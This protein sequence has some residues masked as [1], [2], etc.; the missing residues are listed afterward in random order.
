[1]VGPKPCSRFIH[2]WDSIGNVPAFALF[3]SPDARISKYCSSSSKRLLTGKGWSSRISS[4]KNKRHWTYGK[5]G[6]RDLRSGHR[7]QN[8][9]H[10]N[11]EGSWRSLLLKSRKLSVRP[12]EI[13]F[14][15][16][17]LSNHVSFSPTHQVSEIKSEVLIRTKSEQ[18][19]LVILTERMPVETVHQR[20]EN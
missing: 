12:P 6:C 15:R 14:L 17:T 9:S 5:Q 4:M 1:M 10:S 16:F 2:E 13:S 7:L 20:N 18:A 19:S 8:R 3:V 11:N